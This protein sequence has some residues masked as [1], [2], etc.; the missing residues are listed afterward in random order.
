MKIL[1][2][3]VFFGRGIFGIVGRFII[4]VVDIGVEQKVS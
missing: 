2:N 3:K 1:V 4:R